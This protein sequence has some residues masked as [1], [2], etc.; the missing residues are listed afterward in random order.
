MSVTTCPN[1]SLSIQN[2]S[3]GTRVDSINVTV[4]ALGT[5]TGAGS[6]SPAGALNFNMMAE[7]SGGGA[8]AE[9]TSGGIP[10]T[11]E[12]TTSDPEFV[13][14]VKGTASSAIKNKISPKGESTTK[15]LL[16]KIPR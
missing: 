4:P 9:R 11:I 14:N 12:G 2:A 6:V 15:G 3:A 13:P 1:R 8:V 16:R 7:L 10:F 5:L